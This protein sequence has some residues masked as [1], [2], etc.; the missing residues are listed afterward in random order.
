MA[1]FVQSPTVEASCEPMRLINSRGVPGTAAALVSAKDGS[2]LLLTSHHVLFGLGAVRGDRVWTLDA[3]GALVAIGRA[4]SG[5][6]G[7]V[8]VGDAVAFVD[9]ALVEL[10]DVSA[11]TLPRVTGTAPGTRGLPVR[12]LG[13]VTGLTAGM[14][15]DDAYYD[16]PYVMGRAWEAPAQL[17]IDSADSAFNFLAAGDSGAGVLD[18]AG[19]LVGLLCGSNGHGAGIA[20]PIAPVL[21]C[22]EVTLP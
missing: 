5:K 20:C 16:M 3:K 14:I 21:A 15:V 8:S 13:A 10:D 4:L 22:L 2:P 7:R 1:A 9:C 19:R 11:V 17:L 6:L 18:D 12:K